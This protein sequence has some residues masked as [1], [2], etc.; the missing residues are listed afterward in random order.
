MCVRGEPLHTQDVAKLSSEPL[1]RC[2]APP[3]GFSDLPSQ[4][5]LILSHPP[6]LSTRPPVPRTET[7]Q[8]PVLLQGVRT[9]P[10]GQLLTPAP[11][12]GDRPPLALPPLSAQGQQHP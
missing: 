1:I 6:L 5:H 10:P 4:A 9:C 3:P 2:L 12:P 8:H 7:Y 11:D